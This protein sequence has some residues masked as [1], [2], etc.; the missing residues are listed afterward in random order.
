M[1]L[2]FDSRLSN[3][4]SAL[5]T[6]EKMKIESE[7]VEEEYK[8]KLS[9]ARKMIAI[10][11][12]ETSNEIA[13]EYGKKTS[14]AEEEFKK[15]LRQAERKIG[16]FRIS[17]KAELDSVICDSAKLIIKELAGIDIKQETIEMILKEDK[18]L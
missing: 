7:E 5:R 4:R 17:A 16:K 11:I 8:A 12:S 2:V 10:K 9:H 1:R 3:V 13:E 14:E 18:K 15:M 6:A